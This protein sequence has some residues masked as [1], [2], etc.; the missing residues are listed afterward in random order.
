MPT[1]MTMT[2]TGSIL[3]IAHTADF[4]ISTSDSHGDT[5]IFAIMGARSGDTGSSKSTKKFTD[6]PATGVTNG[7]I[8]KIA[9]DN[10]VGMDDFYVKFEADTLGKGIWRECIGPDEDHHFNFNTMPHRLVRLFDDSKITPKN[11]FGITF[12]FEAVTATADDG[13]TVDGSANTA[14]NTNVIPKGFLGVVL[15]SSNNLTNLCGIV[16]KL[17]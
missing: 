13:R 6:L 3:H 11:P 12:V 10:T 9:G 14:S 8:T 5:D 2:R 4:D 17:K 15:L 16:L 7:F 1:G